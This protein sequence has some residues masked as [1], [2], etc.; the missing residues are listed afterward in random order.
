[1]DY[2]LGFIYFN[3]GNLINCFKLWKKYLENA[4]RAFDSSLKKVEKIRT[5]LKQYEILINSISDF[6][7]NL[8]FVKKYTI[9]KSN[10][11]RKDSNYIS[12]RNSQN[13]SIDLQ[14]FSN[15]KSKNLRSSRLNKK[16]NDTLLINKIFLDGN[17]SSGNKLNY[18]TDL[19]QNIKNIEPNLK[20]N[21][22]FIYDYYKAVSIFYVESK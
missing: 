3:S 12:S 8:Q 17:N 15:G 5:F 20:Q 4:D 9:N 18:Y 10:N 14:N 1:M 7:K 19:L 22:L 2:W 11:S 21:K 6:K 16:N 13:S